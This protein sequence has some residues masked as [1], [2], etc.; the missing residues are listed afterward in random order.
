MRD[1]FSTLVDRLKQRNVM[2]E[3]EY[4]QY[5]LHFFL[6]GA[7]AADPAEAKRYAIKMAGIAENPTRSRISKVHNDPRV[8]ETLAIISE[9]MVEILKDKDIGLPQ[10][11]S[12]ALSCM[13]ISIDLLKQELEAMRDGEKE[14]SIWWLKLA[15][16]YFDKITRLSGNA[17]PEKKELSGPGGGPIQT[18]SIDLSNLSDKELDMLESLVNKATPY[19]G[20]D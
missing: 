3:S 10:L 15:G 13:D 17:A 16:E 2:I 1:Y 4:V 6:R 14:L 7:D 20:T 5:A 18:Q 11:F 9:E 12:K 19:E 8:Q